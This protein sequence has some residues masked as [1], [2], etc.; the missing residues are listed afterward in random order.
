MDVAE[1]KKGKRMCGWF[2]EVLPQHWYQ[3][4]PDPLDPIFDIISIVL[5]GGRGAGCYI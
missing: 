5:V 2:I 1:N 4:L 3:N